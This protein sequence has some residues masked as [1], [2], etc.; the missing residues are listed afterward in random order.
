MNELVKRYFQWLLQNLA[1]HSEASNSSSTMEVDLHAEES[2]SSDAGRDVDVDTSVGT[3]IG[4]ANKEAANLLETVAVWLTQYIQV[5]QPRSCYRGCGLRELQQDV[6]GNEE[7]GAIVTRGTES[8]GSILRILETK[9][10]T[11]RD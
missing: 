6:E 5:C 9:I 11:C 4:I 10:S 3:G 1:I 2:Q 8:P 7:R